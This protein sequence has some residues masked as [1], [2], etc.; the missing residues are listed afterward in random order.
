MPDAQEFL[1]DGV[2]AERAGAL[3][4]ALEAYEAAAESADDAPTRIESLRRLADVYRSRCE[5]DQ[6]LE[7]ARL[8]QV[9]AHAAKEPQLLAEAAIAEAN[10]L[11]S[12]GNFTQ[13]IPMLDTIAGSDLEPRLRAIALQNL[14]SIYAQTGQ[15]LTAERAFRESLANFN[16]AG[17]ARGEAI[18][19]N[20]L[21]RLAL[22]ANDA[23]A[24]RPLLERALYLARDQEDSELA[25]LA[26]LNLAS[27]LCLAGDNDRAQDLAMAALGYF[28]GCQNAWREIECLRLIGDINVR[29][30]DI[31]NAARC[32][33]LAL[34]LSEQI[35]SEAEI[36]LSTERLHALKTR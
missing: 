26:G 33:D 11:I 36:R 31:S 2:R 13:A 23:A 21:G 1:A 6:A 3:D 12:Q 28:A 5:W 8:A 9:V 17:Y 30:E 27:A 10:V 18:A 34:K 19:L 35:G 24:A 15:P 32:Y 16:R 20:N 29:C 4:R 25:A 22:D 14:G 7:A